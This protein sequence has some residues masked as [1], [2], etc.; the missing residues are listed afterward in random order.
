MI[1]GNDFNK[2]RKFLK[3]SLTAIGGAAVLSGLPKGLGSLAWAAG[4]SLETT[5]AKLGFIAL[6]DAAPLFV[7][8]EKGFFKKI[9]GGKDKK[10]EEPTKKENDY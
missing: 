8:E 2:R 6:T 10:K 7:A 9:F 4:G 5:T 3:H 1:G